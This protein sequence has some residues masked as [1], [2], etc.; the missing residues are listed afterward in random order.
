MTNS[1][2]E[3]VYLFWTHGESGPEELIATLDRGLLEDLCWTYNR[4]LPRYD[5]TEASWF[6][7]SHRDDETVMGCLA[8][9][10][11]KSDEELSVDSGIHDLMGG[12][13]GLHFQVTKLR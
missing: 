9:L 4:P 11:K 13:G 5:N 2:H 10:L 3:Y 8:D 12:W 1:L 6:D 7:T